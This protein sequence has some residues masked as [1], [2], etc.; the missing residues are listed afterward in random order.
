[1]STGGHN[2]ARGPC[3]CQAGTQGLTM[4]ELG[5]DRASVTFSNV[6]AYFSEEE[7]EV[8]EER[9]KELYRGVM[10]EIHWILIS[11]EK[12]NRKS[13]SVAGLFVLEKPK[14]P[15]CRVSSGNDTGAKLFT[16][17]LFKCQVTLS[18]MPIFC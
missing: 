13:W 17:A 10:K 9:Q 7:W 16:P 4:A 11:L 3:H 18:S 6:A 15:E 5:S 1:M 8:L 14:H 2:T 12:P